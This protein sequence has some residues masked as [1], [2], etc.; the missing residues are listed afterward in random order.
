M[1]WHFFLALIVAIPIILIPAVLIWYLNVGGI[2]RGA[3]QIFT[4]RSARR[5]GGHPI[6][7]QEKLKDKKPAG[8]GT[9]ASQLFK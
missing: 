8:K 9:Q 3:K 4:R 5:A 1:E 6:E 7:E 2:Y